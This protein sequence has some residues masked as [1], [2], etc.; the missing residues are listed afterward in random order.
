MDKD[1]LIKALNAKGLSNSLISLYYNT[2]RALPFIAQ[3][4]PD[5]RVSS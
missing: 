4:F 2:G 1:K 5:G 3:R